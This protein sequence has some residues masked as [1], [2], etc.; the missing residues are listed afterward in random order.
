[1][2]KTRMEN[3]YYDPNHHS[4][5]FARSPPFPFAILILA[6]L[7]VACAILCTNNDT[8]DHLINVFDAE[9]KNLPDEEK[10]KHREWYKMIIGVCLLFIILAL[11]WILYNWRKEVK[12]AKLGV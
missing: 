5:H 1:M 7:A 2:S 3:G 12:E 9:F 10:Q 11:A 8:L 6:G 4:K